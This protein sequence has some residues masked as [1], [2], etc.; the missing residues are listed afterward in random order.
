MRKYIYAF[1]LAALSASALLAHEKELGKGLKLEFT[2][3]YLDPQGRTVADDQGIHYHHE[4][5]SQQSGITPVWVTHESK[6]LPEKYF[7]SYPLYYSGQTMRYQIR[8]SNTGNRSLKRITVVAIQEYLNASGE[9]GVRIGPDAVRDWFVP[10]LKK[11]ESVTLEGSILIPVLGESGL[12]QTHI[13]VFKSRKNTDDNDNGPAEGQDESERQ[14]S[15]HHNHGHDENKA[16]RLIFEEIQAGIWCP[17]G[18]MPQ[19]P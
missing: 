9:V 5:L 10:R 13:Q 19:K 6:I 3:T 2:V 17:P 16:D 8:L 12:D 15:I 7:G 4:V 11:G 14:E 18:L 1:A